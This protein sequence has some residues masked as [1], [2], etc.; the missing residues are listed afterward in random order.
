MLKLLQFLRSNARDLFVLSIMAAGSACIG[1]AINQFR[2]S[3]LPWVYVPKAVRIQQTAAMLSMGNKRPS[4]SNSAA[5][6]EVTFPTDAPDVPS[7]D[8][9]A[10]LSI[11]EKKVKGIVL[12]ARPERFYQRG[13]VPGA[14]SLP[15]E[16][17]ET[18]Y[19]KNRPRLEIDKSQPIVVYC[20][21]SS[22]EDSHLVATAL[23]KLSYTRVLIFKGGWN[24]WT[25]A[26]PREKAQ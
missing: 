5:A 23:I 15:R 21:N 1:F 7:V 9:P 22:C 13:H 10:F 3:P 8:F 17:F 24:A 4:T 25:D 16:E 6:S 2:D 11:V 26:F 12:D 18:A 20:S 14:I 19:E